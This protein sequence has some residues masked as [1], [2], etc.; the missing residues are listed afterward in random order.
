MAFDPRS[1]ERLKELGRTLPKPLPAS[2]PPSQGPKRASEQRH[3]VETETDPD[4]LFRE[5]ITV[6][7]DG[8]VPPHLLERLRQS[9]QEKLAKP[10]VASPSG[11]P[12]ARQVRGTNPGNG[13]RRPQANQLQSN[14]GLARGKAQQPTSEGER[15]LYADFQ[16]L[17]HHD[18]QEDPAPGPQPLPRPD[19]SERLKPRP[20][21]RR[22]QP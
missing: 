6:S 10:P 12:Q 15:Q 4:A 1:L 20:T 7:P 14:R 11:Q 8:T 18:P 19:P 5:L 2:A 3:R 9:E 13:R 17:L 16:D 21:D 22:R